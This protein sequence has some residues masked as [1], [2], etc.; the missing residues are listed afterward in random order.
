MFSLSIYISIFVLYLQLSV[1]F[2]MLSLLAFF[3]V[4]SIAGYLFDYSFFSLVLSLSFFLTLYSLFS[5]SL[6]ACPYLYKYI[7]SFYFPFSLSPLS[8][9]FCFLI[10]LSTH[11]LNADFWMV[12]YFDRQST[13]N[14]QVF[15]HAREPN[16]QHNKERKIELGFLFSS[17]HRKTVR[18]T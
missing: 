13:K 8:I 12:C 2:S 10:S 15:T 9:P 16:A 1:L 18:P 6:P 3:F 17:K 11:P 14:N 7:Y 4:F 5:P